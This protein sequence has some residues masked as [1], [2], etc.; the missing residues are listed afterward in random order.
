MK[1]LA[2]LVRRFDGAHIDDKRRPDGYG[3][4][5][6]VEDP[7]QDP[8]LEQMLLHM[9]FKWAQSRAAFYFPEKS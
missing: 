1:T 3:G 8:K 2:E 4:R 7:K 6:W 5:L 9:G